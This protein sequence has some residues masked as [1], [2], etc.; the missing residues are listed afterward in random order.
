MYSHMLDVG[1]VTSA[2]IGNLSP[3]GTYYFAATSYDISG[4]ESTPS[5]EVVYTV[6]GPAGQTPL[7]QLAFNSRR[8]AALT[9]TAP[10][11]Y[12]YDVLATTSFTNWMVL[13]SV[14]AD[15]NGNV[16]FTDSGATTNR[17]RFYRLHQTFP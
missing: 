14:T 11:G 3:G 17:L 4:L 5:S 9:A 15:A 7:L 10:A 8:Q 12:H 13:G 2:A 1:N 6:P 16:Q